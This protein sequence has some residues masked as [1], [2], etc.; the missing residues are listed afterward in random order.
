MASTLSAGSRS[1]SKSYAAVVVSDTAATGIY[2][3]RNCCFRVLAG[4]SRDIIMNT[5]RLYR[6]T[7]PERSA[8]YEKKEPWGGD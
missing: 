8:I 6:W 4:K 1:K 2:G 3:R 5:V 7:G